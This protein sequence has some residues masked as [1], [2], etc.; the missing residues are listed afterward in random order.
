M[1]GKTQYYHHKHFLI[2]IYKG[3]KIPFIIPNLIT[4][5]IELYENHARLTITFFTDKN[6]NGEFSLANMKSL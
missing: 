2:F 4:F 3:K 5:G 6:N 1:D